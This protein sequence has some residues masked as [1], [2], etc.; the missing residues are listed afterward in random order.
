MST[1]AITMIAPQFKITLTA[2]QTLE[3]G[4]LSVIWGQIDHFLLQSVALLL[5][6]DIACGVALLGDMTTG[7]LV[8]HLRK[9][10]H[11]IDDPKFAEMAKKFCEDMGPLIST[12]NHIMHGLWGLYLPGKNPNKAQPGCLFVKN[13]DHPVFP[14]KVT[15]VANKAAEQTYV[16]SAIWHHL[17]GIEPPTGNPKFYFGKH[18]PRVPKGM[19]L[20]H[21]ARPPKGHQK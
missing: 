3:V 11:R 8:G 15:E 6:H 9:A 13:P 10:R 5:T 17:N 16:I 1:D 4:R 2:R 7:P 18:D 19:Q 12:R 21:V 20:I 14:A